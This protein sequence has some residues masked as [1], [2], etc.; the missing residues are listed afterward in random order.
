MN[1][2]PT[3]N[4]TTRRYLAEPLPKAPIRNEPHTYLV[5]PLDGCRESVSQGELVTIDRV[6]RWFNTEEREARMWVS[7]G[8]WF[9]Q[10]WGT[11]GVR[12]YLYPDK[13]A[14]ESGDMLFSIS[15]IG[16]FLRRCMNHGYEHRADGNSPLRGRHWVVFASS[17]PIIAGIPT[18]EVKEDEYERL[19]FDEEFRRSATATK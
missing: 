4:P 15:A 17:G 19:I 11:T 9:P 6:A 5:G 16:Q 1:T 18:G 14:T 12:C 8:V 7:D 13:F 3:P 10:E 2:E